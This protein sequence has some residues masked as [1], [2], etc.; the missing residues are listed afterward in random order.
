[1]AKYNSG[2][3]KRFGQRDIT[4]DRYEYLGLEQAE[5]DLGDPTVGVGST[6][7][8]P[9]PIGQTYILAAVDG[10]EGKRYWAPIQTEGVEV[11]IVGAQGS[12][13][14]QGTQGLQ[15]LQGAA[16]VDGADGTPGFRGG[17]RYD[18]SSAV[19]NGTNNPTSGKFQFDNGT[20]ANI[21]K[22]S[23]SDDTAEGTDISAF[24]ATWDDSTSSNIRG[25][26][27]IQSADSNDAT[28]A[29]FSITG[30]SDTTNNGW[31]VLSVTPISGGFPSNSEKCV[32]SFSRTGNQGT[33]GLQGLQGLQGSIGI[34]G[35]G[36]DS[37]LLTYA[38]L[39]PQTCLLYTS[40]AADE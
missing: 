5:P 28:Y 32:I 20:F 23:I 17:I 14:L 3:K 24:I 4:T 36:G 18:F 38:V 12:Q 15:G 33:Q 25:H 10:Y 2:R 9:K 30:D 21:T 34:Q 19:N 16:A 35:L 11:D 7:A 26:I 29:I 1:M 8:N 39:D 37:P 22:L 13:G 31:T 6:G 40:D 27:V